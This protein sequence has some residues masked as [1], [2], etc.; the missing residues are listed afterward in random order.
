[1]PKFEPDSALIPSEE[2]SIAS[3]ITTTAGAA[4]ESEGR[5]FPNPLEPVFAPSRP[6]GTR[7]YSHQLK[8]P[9]TRVMQ[10]TA[11][12]EITLPDIFQYAPAKTDIDAANALSTLYLSHVTS[13]VDCVRFC[14]DKMFFRLFTQFQGTLT[15]PVQKLLIHPSIS[16]WVKECDYIMY[17][18]MIKTTA[19]LTLQVLPVKVIKFFDTVSQCLD[20]HLSRT[21]ASLPKHVL[22]AK[23][24]PATIFSQLLNRML[25]VNQAAHAAGVV[26]IDQGNRDRM[27]TEMVKFV[28]PKC[29]MNAFI[30]DCGYDE[31]VYKLLT[32]DVRQ[33][34][35]PLTTDPSLE[36]NTHYE[37]AAYT[38]N[39]LP[40]PTE[41]ELDKLC[42]FLE[43]MKTRFPT[44]S[45]QN[46]IHYVQGITSGILRD[47]VM[48]AG[49]SYNPWL[50]TKCYVDELAL[51]LAHV[52]GFLERESPYEIARAEII[53]NGSSGFTS[54]GINGGNNGDGSG[55][56]SRYSSTPSDIAGSASGRAAFHGSGAGTQ[57]RAAQA[58]GIL[59]APHPTGINMPTFSGNSQHTAIAP[60][61]ATHPA[62]QYAHIP[63]N[64]D[65]AMDDDQKTTDLELDDSGIGLSL[66]GEGID[67]K[68]SSEIHQ[69]FHQ[70]Q[71]SLEDSLAA[72]VQ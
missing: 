16:P 20:Q 37:I 51:W 13:L 27:W 4:M 6:T 12:E 11:P 43:G 59:I 15:V 52:G 56:N 23:L 45:S 3:P 30:P 60:M 24:E 57:V 17:Q 68:T 36:S 49:A 54:N 10:P 28:Q 44:V 46:L 8:F 66:I 63:I 41:F 53:A 40:Q 31:E 34:L 70:I 7:S 5:V 26:L 58:Q 1:M 19:P 22:D 38:Q 18:Q 50:I 14:K 65:G 29:M 69:S 39:A 67:D 25:R 47:I 72:Y 35:L 21:F 48:Q 62:E 9:S 2:Q 55:N 64:T 32:N 71:S 42:R 61:P 33:L